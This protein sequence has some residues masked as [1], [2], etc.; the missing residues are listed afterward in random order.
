MDLRV[1]QREIPVTL[2]LLDGRDL[3][4]VLWVPTVGPDGGPAHL[5]DRLNEASPGFIPFG[6]GSRI[7]LVHDTRILTVRASADPGDETQ[8]E[9]SRKLLVKL[10]LTSG[11]AV[12]G[13][14]VYVMPQDH[15]RLQD[16]LNSAKRF[17]PLHIEDDLVLVNRDQIVTAVALRGE[18]T[19]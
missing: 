6:E 9:L 5:V 3:D 14:L 18:G 17:I 10:H 8:I 15:E 12:I 19:S 7:H 1:P 16:Y 11:A 13:R 4:G 2:H